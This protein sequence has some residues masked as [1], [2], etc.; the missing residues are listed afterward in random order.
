MTQAATAARDTAYSGV[1]VSDWW[2]PAGR[3][4]SLVD[5]WHRP[6]GGVVAR[7]V[8]AP[9]EAGRSSAAGSGD[10]V[11]TTT[12]SGEQLK[13]LLANYEVKYAGSGSAGG[14][15]AQVIA[16]R[17]PGGG[18]VAR[19][20]L[21]KQTKLPLRREIF[22]SHAHLISNISLIHLKLGAHA[23]ARMPT[24]AAR[25]WTRQLGA[26]EIRALRKQGWPVPPHLAGSLRLFSASETHNSTG[27]VVDMS[28]SD[29]LSDISLFVQRG[30]LARVM[31]GWH[32]AA[33]G[34]H[35]AFTLD[36]D[37]RA[38]CWSS[39]GFVF[40][41]IADAP[42]ATVDQ[43]VATLASNGPPGFWTRLSRGFHRLAS[44]ANLFR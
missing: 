41:M 19:F 3:S 12:V 11:V 13:L 8:A 30:E 36:A 9:G 28:Y 27:Q 18:L 32:R 26:R 44:L 25:P 14:R 31:R 37:D 40:T 23:V 34:G 24:A 15:P 29:G 38:V 5:V 43:S 2:G 6:G 10:P 20:W 4:T 7:E 17:R 21:D 39:G 1:Q 42:A 16:V 22:G 33:I 35:R